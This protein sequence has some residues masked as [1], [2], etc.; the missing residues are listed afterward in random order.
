MNFSMATIVKM[1][2]LAHSGQIDVT[3]NSMLQF[4]AHVPLVAV[5]QQNN[6]GFAVLEFFS[7]NV[8]IPVT[9]AEEIE[10]KERTKYVLSCYKAA[11]GLEAPVQRTSEPLNWTEDTVFKFSGWERPSTA[12]KRGVKL[13]NPSFNVSTEYGNR[14]ALD[15]LVEFLN[16]QG[17]FETNEFISSPSSPSHVSNQ[18]SASASLERSGS[19]GSLPSA[20]AL[21]ALQ[22][23][24]ESEIQ[25]R[26]AL[27]QTVAQQ[28]SII[29]QLSTSLRSL[30]SQIPV[31]LQD[32]ET[33]KKHTTVA[34]APTEGDPLS[35]NRGVTFNSRSMAALFA[36]GL[37][38]RGPAPAAPN[39]NDDDDDDD[40]TDS[41]GTEPMSD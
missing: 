41:E 40:D 10:T 24:L 29:E 38:F 16:E 15:G 23:Q 36:N 32:I 2:W 19:A 31:I 7:G 27:E 21:Q 3:R 33:L 25:A 35:A 8:C 22:N 6:E 17:W 5:P 28:F 26:S 14:I 9:I 30:Q 20:S 4:I 18:G 39:P 11:M 12:S 34:A 37:N 1:I 13:N